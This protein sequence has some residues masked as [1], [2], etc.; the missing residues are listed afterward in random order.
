MRRFQ[1]AAAPADTATRAAPDSVAFMEL[2]DLDVV[3]HWELV[4]RADNKSALLR[5]FIDVVGA[6]AGNPVKG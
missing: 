2:P 1:Q 3:Q 6:Y 4:W 5:R